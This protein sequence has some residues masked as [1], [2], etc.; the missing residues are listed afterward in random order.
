MY[1]NINK[2]L[3]YYTVDGIEFA[4]KINA[5]IYGTS[6]K[7]QVKWHFHDE[8]FSKY[9]WHVEPTETLDYFYRRRA[10]EL[11]EKYDY[12][13]LSYSGGSDSHNMVD[14]FLNEGLF[15][16]EIVIN[17]MTTVA[18][19]Y[20]DYNTTNTSATNFQAEYKLQAVPRLQEIANRSPKTK[21]TSID[22]S[23][24][25]FRFFDSNDESWITRCKEYISPGQNQRFN[26]F[27]FTEMQKRFDKN[28]KIGLIFGLEK[29]RTFISQGHFYLTFADASMNIS[30]GSEYNTEHDNVTF[31]LFYWGENCEQLI[32]KQAHVVKRYVELTPEIR[33]HWT[34]FDADTFRNFQEPIL[35]PILYS[36]WNTNWFQTAKS[37][38][39]WYN[40]WDAFLHAEFK[41]TTRYKVWEK[42]VIYLAAHAKD[43]IKY[44]PDNNGNLRP[45]GLVPFSHFYKIADIQT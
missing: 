3:G 21:I 31:E 42:G 41:N 19:T 39:G 44:I 1:T 15:I 18:D 22:V 32:A 35:K 43:Y 9:P 13:I 14:A 11:R 37:K 45:S 16:D 4:S 23:D 7:K 6:V 2:N 28:L 12:I 30:I 26:Y 10:K 34:T 27:Y 25:I 5:C 20:T 38:S 33:K 8:T 29:P 24:N 36:S 40:D 17:H